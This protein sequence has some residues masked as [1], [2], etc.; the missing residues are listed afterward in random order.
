VRGVPAHRTVWHS[1]GETPRHD[2]LQATNSLVEVAGGGHER[3]PVPRARYS[4]RRS[5]NEIV[6][7]PSRSLPCI[8]RMGR[9]I[10][11]NSRKDTNSTTFPDVPRKQNRDCNRGCIARLPCLHGAR[12]PALQSTGDT[13]LEARPQPSLLSRYP[14]SRDIIEYQHIFM[15]NRA[16]LAFWLF[17]ACPLHQAKYGTRQSGNG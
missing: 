8:D 2:R 7:A 1:P 12:F 17:I 14:Y 13:L 15:I 10:R 9:H 5:K 4:V 3:R 6:A 11:R 16:P